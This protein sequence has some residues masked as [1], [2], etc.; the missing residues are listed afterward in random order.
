MAADRCGLGSL[1]P[2]SCRGRAESF[3]RRLSNRLRSLGHGSGQFDEEAAGAA[4]G[5]APTTDSPEYWGRDD[6]KDALIASPPDPSKDTDRFY[7]FDVVEQTSGTSSP[8]NEV[9]SFIFIIQKINI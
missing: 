9:W 6:A 4:G 8:A 5:A 7:D 3:A 2:T 1:L